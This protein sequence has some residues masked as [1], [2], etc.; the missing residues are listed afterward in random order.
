[1]MQI[2]IIPGPKRGVTAAFIYLH[3][4]LGAAECSA[5]LTMGNQALNLYKA[6]KD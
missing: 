6:L 2:V 5:D 1:M 4:I 3:N